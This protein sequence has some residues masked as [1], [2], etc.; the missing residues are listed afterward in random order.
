MKRGSGMTGWV[1]RAVKRLLTTLKDSRGVTLY[2]TTAVVAMTA[3]IAAVAL[4]VAIDRIESA[5]EGRAASEATT[6]ANAMMRFFEDTGR[7]PGE[8]EIRTPGSVICF[9]QT[10]VP[11]TDPNT[12]TLLPD[13][14]NLGLIDARDFLGRTCDTITPINT[15]NVNDYL[16]RK[17]SVVNYPNWHGPYVE[18][19]A[20]DPWDRAYVINVLPLIFSGGIDDPGLGKFADTG[21]KLGFAW[22]LSV[23]PDRLLQTALTASQLA[24]GSDDTG[25]NLGKRLESS[26]GGK[27][28]KALTPSTPTGVQPQ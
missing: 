13:A 7:W 9:L 17:P 26:A 20:S 28:A 14:R 6:L 16:V 1:G 19:I 3:V 10:G 15:L 12:G 21:G 18:G 22:I 25:K 8:A 24:S 2:E 11:T 5:K 27:S 23:G 4:P